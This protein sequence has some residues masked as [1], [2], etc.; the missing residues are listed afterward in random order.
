MD[1][2]QSIPN[3]PLTTTKEFSEQNGGVPIGGA[4]IVNVHAV[5]V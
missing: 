4:L 2:D 1:R 5:L 3:I